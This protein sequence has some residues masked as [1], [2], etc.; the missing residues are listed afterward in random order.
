MKSIFVFVV[1][2]GGSSFLHNR[3]F[4]S[5]AADLA[6]LCGDVGQYFSMHPPPEGA[7]LPIQPENHLYSRIFTQYVPYIDLTA[8]PRGIC[9]SRDPRDVAISMFYSQASAPEIDPVKD[10]A[11]SLARLKILREMGIEQWIAREGLEAAKHEYD[12]AQTLCNETPTVLKTSYEKMLADWDS[13][14]GEILDWLGLTKLVDRSRYEFESEV[15][16]P[17][18]G[19]RRPQGQV[20]PGTWRYVFTPTLIETAQRLLGSDLDAQGLEWD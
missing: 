11:E 20:T 7:A 9:V 19:I 4:A 3:V 1:H 18:A 14:F 16:L 12:L 2:R 13:F 8:I 6:M 17:E 10:P 5:L 15:R